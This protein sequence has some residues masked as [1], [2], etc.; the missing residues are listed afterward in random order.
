MRAFVT[1]ACLAGMAALAVSAGPGRAS[2]P[3]Q[4]QGSEA[5]AQTAPAPAAVFELKYRG[6]SMPDDPLA[7][8]S[9]F[10]FGERETTSDPFVRAVKER[11]AESDIVYN[12]SLS[13]AQWGVVELKDKK[14]VAFYFDTN[15]DGKVSDDE[16]FPLLP[17]S[18]PGFYPYAFITSDFLLRTKTGQEIPFRALLVGYPMGDRI[19]YMWSPSCVLEGQA[20]LAGEP[21]RLVLFPRNFAG[22][23]TT[24]GACALALLPIGQEPK[25][26]VSRD[27]L[28]SLIQYRGTFYRVKLSGTHEK[29]KT[30]RVT[31]EKDTA[32]TGQVALAL[33]SKEPAKARL[34]HSALLGV[35][36][37]TIHLRVTDGLIALPG[38][39]YT[40]SSGTVNYG[41]QSD[42]EWQVAFTEGPGFTMEAGQTGKIELGAPTVTISAIKEQDRYASDVKERTTFPRGTEIYLAPQIKGTAGEVY[43]RFSQKGTGSNP[44]TDFKTHLTIL[45]PDGKQVVSTDMEYG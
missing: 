24:F 14:P 45:G 17:A 27:P 2:P 11:V 33:K 10:G 28:S 31:L 36:D 26:I 37:R 3:P 20:S 44:M 15:G 7:A 6:L 5:T 4:G 43:G 1:T 42:D 34:T 12:G 25:G 18:R 13:N 8:R 39:Q 19:G 21:L 35:T 32:P 38:G 23:F 9:Y 29:D 22:S 30:V 40:L 41:A 16:R